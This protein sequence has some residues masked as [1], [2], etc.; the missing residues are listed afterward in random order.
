MRAMWLLRSNLHNCSVLS[1][2]HDHVI[3]AEASTWCTGEDYL[4]WYALCML[5]TVATVLEATDCPST[6]HYSQ[7]EHSTCQTPF[8]LYLKRAPLTSGQNQLWK[9]LRKE[10]RPN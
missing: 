8:I 4:F 7:D 1:I 5:I 2:S 9:F 6:D 10:E 3:L